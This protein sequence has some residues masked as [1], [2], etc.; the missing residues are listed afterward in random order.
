MQL[1]PGFFCD[2]PRELPI[3][4]PLEV[5]QSPIDGLGPHFPPAPLITK[6][7]ELIKGLNLLQERVDTIEVLV[8][9][10]KLELKLGSD[11][12]S[13]LFSGPPPIVT[14]KNVLFGH[15]MV[16]LSHQL[17]LN[18]ILDGLDADLTVTI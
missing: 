14:I 1:S 13:F 7:R 15:F 11:I 5:I 18:Q 4:V 3:S 6:T 8:P 12:P 9:L 17:G 10:C 16:T 2:H